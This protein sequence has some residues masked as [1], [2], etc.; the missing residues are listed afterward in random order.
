MNPIV[1]RT[2]TVFIFLS[3][4][5]L[6]I[7]LNS[8]DV[9]FHYDDFHYLQENL[10]I[11]S[12]KT[13]WDRLSEDYSSVFTGRPFLL[14]TFFLNYK[15][16]GLDTFGYHLLNLLIHI[17]NAFLLY[18]LFFRYGETDKGKGYSLR[19]LLASVLFLIHPINTE[20]VTYISSRS[21]ELSAFFMLASMLCFFRATEN[22]FHLGFYTMSVVFF[23]LGL[24]TKETAIV[25][26]ALIILVDYFFISKGSRNLLS[27]LKYYL[28]YLLLLGALSVLYMHYITAPSSGARRPWPVHIF[29]EVKVFSEYLR[30]LAVPVGLNIDHDIQPSVFID[31]YVAFSSALILTLIFVSIF[32]RKKYFIISFSILWFFINLAPFLAIRLEEFMAERWLYIASMGFC[33]GLSGILMSAAK[34]YRRLGNVL[35]IAVIIL[36]ST[37]AVVRN[38]VYASEV[39]L[40]EDSAK[41]Q[42]D[43]YGPYVN[44]SRAYRERGNLAKAIENANEAIEKGR[45]RKSVVV[46]AYLNLSAIYEDMGEYKKAEEALKAIEKY[47]TNYY[48]YYHNLGVIYM[49]MGKHEEALVPFKKAIELRPNSPTIFFLLGH[50]Y[51]SLS[52]SEKAKEYFMLTT[53]SVPQNGQEY[54]SQGIAFS[55]LGDENKAL[56]CF[57]EAVK[58]DPFDVDVRNYLANTLFKIGHFDIAFKQYSIVSE[59]SPQ[60]APAYTGMGKA[61]LAT[62]N[63]REARKHFNRALSLLP[64]GSS[65]RK[66]LLELL[67]KT[68]G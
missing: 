9:P 34:S 55:K 37:L 35:I 29:T 23:I 49:K 16:G 52:Q 40:W 67:D 68:K 57:F 24:S 63:L 58:T 42:P 64:P 22:K 8:F 43:N 33:I 45:K 56:D 53:R 47:S 13:L 2:R 7:Y 44:L 28:P 4:I 31:G 19:Y 11:K 32:L 27:R 48:R 65:E 10:Q 59:I 66:E 41:K 26:P 12:F 18:L 17:I 20:S 54:I 46:L 39:S 21:S 25:T 3:L 60:Y 15:L 61:M 14:F 36:N 62:G 5:G 6:L 50:C 38:K 1:I 30:L 51:E